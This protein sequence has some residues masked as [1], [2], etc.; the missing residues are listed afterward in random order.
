MTITRTFS[1]KITPTYVATTVVEVC[2][3]RDMVFEVGENVGCYLDT[4]NAIIDVGSLNIGEFPDLNGDESEVEESLALNKAENNSNKIGLKILQRKN[5]IG[6]WLEIAEFILMNYGR[7]NYLDMRGRLGY[8]TRLLEKNDALAV[9]L[10]DYGD[11]LLWDTDYI[12]VDFAVT[13]EV[14][15]K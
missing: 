12:K 15:K 9:Q 3:F 14:K 11:G 13:I 1:A 5:N 8:P 2:H 4:A 7:K 6:D 10:V